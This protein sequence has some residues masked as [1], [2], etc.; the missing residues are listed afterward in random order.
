[1]SNNYDILDK[2]SSGVDTWNE[3]RRGPGVGKLLLREADLSES[4]LSNVDFSDIDASGIDLYKSDLSNA[5]LKMS[6]FEGA[7][8]SNARLCAIGGYKANFRSA[9]LIEAD[10]EGADLSEADLRDADLRGANLR[11]ANLQGALLNGA[12]LDRANL[13]NASLVDADV[14]GAS[15][16]FANMDS[17]NLTTMHYG[18]YRLMHG[19]Y[20]GV[21]GLDSSFGNSI[22]VRDAKDQDY[23]DTLEV[24]ISRLPEGRMKNIEHKLFRLWSLIDYGR[25]LFKV[26]FYAFLIASVY[27]C[28]YSLDMYFGWGMMDYSNSAQSW[29]T[30]FY[31]SIVTYT[32]LGF[33][34]VT[35]NHWLGEIIIISEVIVGYFT[36]G[37][38]L[39][40]LAN[41]IAR[42]S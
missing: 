34:D 10:L 3:W 6:I 1:M 15:F 39:A 27:A 42:R 23:L 17:A 33:G 31:Y 9:F 13:S 2:L 14:T 29:F 5:N 30:P 22:F 24:M 16:S 32:T 12:R 20:Y 40:I 7:D 36:L 38:L 4:D 19:L 41:T 8:F 25:S 37:L 21:R 28:V 35:A 18:G 11:N 26:T